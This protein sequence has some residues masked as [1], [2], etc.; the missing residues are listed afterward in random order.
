MI[1][2]ITTLL[3]LFGQE[4]KARVT[5]LCKILRMGQQN[6]T[7]N[8]WR[9]VATLTGLPEE[10]AGAPSGAA[11]HR[12]QLTL[13]MQFGNLPNKMPEIFPLRSYCSIP[14]RSALIYVF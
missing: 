7:P 12:P 2:M 6:D 14:Y 10:Q 8:C 5:K 9:L 3:S 1:L 11:S 4:K 13:E